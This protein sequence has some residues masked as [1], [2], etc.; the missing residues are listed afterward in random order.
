[1]TGGRTVV[2]QTQNIARVLHDEFGQWNR[3]TTIGP[4]GALRRPPEDYR[5]PK[6][7]Y[8]WLLILPGKGIYE[9]LNQA[10]ALAQGVY[11]GPS[12]EIY[13]RRR[14]FHISFETDM[15]APS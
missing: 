15:Q 6:R 14:Y 13:P 10:V 9:K 11:A 5:S 2:E 4:T 3:R 1:M 8:S 7:H 12:T